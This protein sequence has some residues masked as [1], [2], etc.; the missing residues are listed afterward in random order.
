MIENSYAA[1]LQH[2]A[3]Q[4]R[5]PLDRKNIVRLYK[6]IST[7]AF[8]CERLNRTIEKYEI[9]GYVES[10]RNLD[11]DFPVWINNTGRVFDNAVLLDGSVMNNNCM[12]FGDAEVTNSKISGNSRIYGNAKVTNS[13]VADLASIKDNAIVT[14]CEII[15]S[16]LIK[17]DCELVDCMVH[18][19][20][21]FGGGAKATNC[22]IGDT[23]IIRGT[24]ILDGCTISGHVVLTEGNHDGITLH[25]EIDVKARRFNDYPDS[26]QGVETFGGGQL[27]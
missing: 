17:D 10:I 22:T 16:P 12:V 4:M 26:S 5:H 7:K 3:L 11:P 14:N 21:T 19:G 8:F 27:R 24:T 2:D 20:V 15:N 18:T 1:L 13:I 23:S 9:G 6:I 25:K